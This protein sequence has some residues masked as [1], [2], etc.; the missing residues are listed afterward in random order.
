MSQRPGGMPDHSSIL[1][2]REDETKARRERGWRQVARIACE[3]LFDL[4]EFF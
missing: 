3:G 2:T 1:L 4:P